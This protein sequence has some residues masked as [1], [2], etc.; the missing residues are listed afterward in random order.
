MNSIYGDSPFRWQ[1]PTA[2][3]W[4]TFVLLRETLPNGAGVPRKRN[5]PVSAPTFRPQ[6]R[7]R[8][9]PRLEPL[10]AFRHSIPGFLVFASFHYHSLKRNSSGSTVQSICGLPPVHVLQ[11]RRSMCR[12]AQ[13][14][15]VPGL[16]FPNSH[17][18]AIQQWSLASLHVGRSM[19]VRCR[20][21]FPSTAEYLLTSRVLQ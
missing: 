17:W 10:L 16:A 2:G 15:L 6:A 5:L 14:H 7:I 11:R 19:H 8:S 12:S 4:I 9:A 21:R 18:P 13:S 1:S 3:R 20:P